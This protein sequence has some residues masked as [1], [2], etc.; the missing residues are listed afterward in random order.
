F[1]SAPPGHI[2][3]EAGVQVSGRFEDTGDVRCSSTPGGRAAWAVHIGNYARMGE[4]YAEL[5]AWLKAEGVKAIGPDWEVYGDWFDDCSQV[6]TDIYR[7]IS[8]SAA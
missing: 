7:L 3:L 5:D 6:R 1:G 4:T 2:D 8:A